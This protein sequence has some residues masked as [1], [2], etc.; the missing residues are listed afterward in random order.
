M[1]LLIILTFLNFLTWLIEEDLQNKWHGKETT[2]NTHMDMRLLEWLGLG[3]ESVKI[4]Q[5]LECL[6]GV[7]RSLS[8]IMP[9]L[10]KAY[11]F[12]ANDYG[13]VMSALI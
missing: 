11:L 8:I 9:L 13:Q 12:S 6:N 10:Y 1:T 7:Q 2:Y 3:A 5:D 4:H